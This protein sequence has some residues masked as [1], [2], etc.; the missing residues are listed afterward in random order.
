MIQC[1][2]WFSTCNHDLPVTVG[3]PLDVLPCSSP[4]FN[5]PTPSPMSHQVPVC[6]ARRQSC[7]Q[8]VR[9]ARADSV[10]REEVV[11]SD[12]VRTEQA[13]VNRTKCECRE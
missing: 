3:L 4:L 9:F 12:G 1:E 2:G 7:T 8:D 11:K 10:V 5:D 6:E 13:S